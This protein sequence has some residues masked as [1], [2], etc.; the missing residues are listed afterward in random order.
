MSSGQGP[1]KRTRVFLQSSAAYPRSA[2]QC[3]PAETGNGSLGAGICEKA[4]VNCPQLPALSPPSRAASSEGGAVQHQP[5]AVPYSEARSRTR[6][7]GREEGPARA[8]RPLQ[9]ARGGAPP[10][11][12][13]ASSVSYSPLPRRGLQLC[14]SR[15]LPPPPVYWKLRSA[16]PLSPTA[17]TTTATTTTATT[18]TTLQKARRPLSLHRRQVRGGRGAGAPSTTPKAHAEGGRAGGRC[19][20][21]V[22]GGWSAS[23]S[24]GKDL[25]MRLSGG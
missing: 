24:S 7:Q 25:Q 14:A 10:P 19:T 15:P 4:P 2:P 1:S 8:R 17:R 13:A 22:R 16:A 21:A 20:G 3:S 5:H 11:A 18:A 9:I 23:R 12:V 6:G